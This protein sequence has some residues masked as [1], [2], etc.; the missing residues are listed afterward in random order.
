M[1][2]TVGQAVERAAESRQSVVNS[3]GARGL[4]RPVGSTERPSGKEQE[5]PAPIQ[6]TEGEMVGARAVPSLRDPIE[7]SADSSCA[8]EERRSSSTASAFELARGPRRTAWADLLQ[9]VFEVDALRCP[10]CGG[11]MRVLSAIT[12]TAVATRILDWIGMP[13]RAP[14][15]GA[16]THSSREPFEKSTPEFSQDDDPGFDFDQSVLENE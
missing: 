14:P 15:L 5:E 7:S 9:R 4:D 8:I 3:A 6:P 11:R 1:P 12:D 10:D 13:S 16:V 2:Q